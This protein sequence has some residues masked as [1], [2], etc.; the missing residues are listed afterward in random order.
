MPASRV[1]HPLLAKPPGHTRRGWSLSAP[2]CW[3][4]TRSGRRW[5]GCGAAIAVVEFAGGAGVGGRIGRV[6]FTDADGALLGRMELWR[7]DEL[8]FALAAPV[9]DRFGQF[10]GEPMIRGTVTW[11]VGDR[12]VVIS[13]RRGHER[14]EELAP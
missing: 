14:F 9:W 2:S 5:S 4:V 11:T 8:A 13:G 12:R 6:G 1:A 7:S 3:A 10:A